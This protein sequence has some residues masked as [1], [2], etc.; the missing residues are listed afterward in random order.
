MWRPTSPKHKLV[1]VSVLIGALA[2]AV[3]A[4]G[5][6][7]PSAARWGLA[8]AALVGLGLWVQ[9]AKGSGAAAVAPRLRVLSRAALS[10]RCGIALVEADGRNFLVAFGD[11]FAQMQHALDPARSGSRRRATRRKEGA[12]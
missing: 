4:S 2:F 9:R 11:G 10:Q 12:R 1:I 7:A 8:A 6:E 3:K 5:M